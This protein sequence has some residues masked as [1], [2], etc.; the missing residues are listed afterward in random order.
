[1]AELF[2]KAPSHRIACFFRRDRDVAERTARGVPRV[3]GIHSS[4]DVSFDFALE[5][6]SELFVELRFGALAENERLQSNEKGGDHRDA[7]IRFEG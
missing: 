7:A 4:L 6:I 3:S 1:L 5:M 2:E